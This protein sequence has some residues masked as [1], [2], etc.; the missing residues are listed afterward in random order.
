M[1]A[2]ISLQRGSAI[3]SAEGSE[4][5]VRDSIT[6]WEKVVAGGEPQPTNDASIELEPPKRE[7]SRRA[8]Q[9]QTG[10]S[11]YDHVFDTVNDRLK[12]IADIPGKSKAEQTRN[13]TLL[14][15]Y[16][17]YLQGLDH[18]QSEQIRAA[19]VDQGCYDNTNFAGYLKGL[20]S[21]V[22]MNTKT[23][24]QYDIKLT[25]PGRKAAKDLADQL[26]GVE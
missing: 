23:G 8:P 6:L 26:Q 3:I 10:I 19:C 15:L 11:Q 25:A 1:E 14:L 7:E 12:L 9:S 21:S 20:K 5:F 16:G 24:G 17:N 4:A 13:V 2:K 22:V 18:V